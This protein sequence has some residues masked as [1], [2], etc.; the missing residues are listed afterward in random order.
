MRF[1]LSRGERKIVTRSRRVLGAV[2]WRHRRFSGADRT[3]RALAAPLGG[4]YEQKRSPDRLGHANG[5]LIR[6]RLFGRLLRYRHLH[7]YL[8]GANG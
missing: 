5:T 3:A 1:S 6:C 8:L 7:S 4:A 2:P